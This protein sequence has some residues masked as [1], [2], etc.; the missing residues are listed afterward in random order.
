[1]K[2]YKELFNE[3]NKNALEDYKKK[4]RRRGYYNVL[5]SILFGICLTSLMGVTLF[6]TGEDDWSNFIEKSKIIWSIYP[7]IAFIG[8]ITVKL[9]FMKNKPSTT[10]L[11]NRATEFALKVYLPDI[12][13]A[14]Q[15]KFY[16][17]SPF[18]SRIKQT[19]QDCHWFDHDDL[20]FDPSGIEL[21]YTE[22]EQ[23]PL[24]PFSITD[25]SCM[26]YL[27]GW[28]YYPN[29]SFR[30]Y[31]DKINPDGKVEEVTF[32]LSPTT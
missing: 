12:R 1:M 8:F 17:Y 13:S 19:I 9:A 25:E 5:W 7:F 27:T 21:D 10:D 6:L 29:L 11:E 24:R 22:D 30:F 23:E 32:Q 3:A 14:L 18:E 15:S 26:Y 20:T 31:F 28:D 4:K 16:F 2:N